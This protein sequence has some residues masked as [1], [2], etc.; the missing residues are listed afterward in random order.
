MLDRNLILCGLPVGL[1]AGIAAWMA[2]G[3]DLPQMG[4]LDAV[5]TTLKPS[6]PVTKVQAGA[7]LAAGLAPPLFAPAES[8]AATAEVSVVLQGL[9]RT[10]RRQAALLAISGRPAEW[11]SVG[12][13]RDDVTLESV[14]ANGATITTP[15][16]TREVSFG[17]V[18]TSAAAA[19]TP[20]ADAAAPTLR[21]PPAPA[22]APSAP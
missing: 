5:V 19:A 6:R 16:G 10:P 11:L 21:A 8:G 22:S 17:A 12:E 1:V 4:A 9:S 15:S 3:R 20:Q 14:R 7:P 18:P 2:F 13:T